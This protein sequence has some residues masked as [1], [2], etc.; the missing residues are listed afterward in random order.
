[1]HRIGE[2]SGLIPSIQS[3]LA[4]Q[5]GLLFSIG[6]IAGGIFLLLAAYH[7]LP[8]GVNAI[9]HLGSVGRGLGYGAIGLGSLTAILSVL[10]WCRQR[11]IIADAAMAPNPLN[12]TWKTLLKYENGPPQ[13]NEPMYADQ[14]IQELVEHSVP[15]EGYKTL[16]V[17]EPSRNDP[18]L[19]SYDGIA[20]SIGLKITAFPPKSVLVIVLSCV[21]GT[22]AKVLEEI[23]TYKAMRGEN[24]P[25]VLHFVDVKRE[26][27]GGHKISLSDKQIQEIAN[28]VGES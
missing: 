3:S 18:C 28:H 19:F 2:G 14:F 7:I 21:E 12:E 5:A 25:F 15:I 11:Q 9:S 1:M 10:F 26:F 23:W 4:P 17:W 13:T 16:I 22:K 6:L 8:S 27:F 24:S 20:H